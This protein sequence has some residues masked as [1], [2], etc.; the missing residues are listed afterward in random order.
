MG[1]QDKEVK[2]SKEKKITLKN[3]RRAIAFVVVVCAA[4][5]GIRAALSST[6]SLPDW[7]IASATVAAIGFLMVSI[8]DK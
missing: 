1:K 3:I 2:T 4:G 8:F 6:N 7:A 5:Y